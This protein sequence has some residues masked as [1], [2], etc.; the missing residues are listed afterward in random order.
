MINCRAVPLY[1]YPRV[2]GMGQ[3]G[4]GCCQLHYG[5]DDIAWGWTSGVTCTGGRAIIPAVCVGEGGDRSLV[6]VG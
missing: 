3:N 1:R 5:T 2:P 6:D 4:V